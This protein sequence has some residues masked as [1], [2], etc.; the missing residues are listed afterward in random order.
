MFYPFPDTRAFGH[1]DLPR[2]VSDNQARNSKRVKEVFLPWVIP[3]GN[4]I[5]LGKI[6]DDALDT[7][8]RAILK[9]RIRD[10]LRKCSRAGRVGIIF[11]ETRGDW[12]SGS[13]NIL[14]RAPL[15][16]PIVLGHHQSAKGFQNSCAMSIDLI[17]TPFTRMRGEDNAGRPRSFATAAWASSLYFFLG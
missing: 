3:T 12:V 7:L 1:L 14:P 8:T 15:S 11:L 13:R 5:V 16:P 4:I 9:P 17:D 6:E 10:G 2:V